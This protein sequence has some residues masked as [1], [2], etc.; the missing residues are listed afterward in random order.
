MYKRTIYGEDPWVSIHNVFP[1]QDN[2]MVYG[3]IE[4][5]HHTQI[6]QAHGGM[7]V[8][9]RKKGKNPVCVIKVIK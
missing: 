3:E 5:D 9:I 2:Q 8:F 4:S 7:D 1:I 6:L